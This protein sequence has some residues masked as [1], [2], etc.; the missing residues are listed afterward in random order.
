MNGP[1]PA[2]GTYNGADATAVNAAIP[3]HT[4]GQ[5]TGSTPSPILSVATGPLGLNDVAAN[6]FDLTTVAGLNAL[7]AALT[8]IA[9]YTTTSGPPLNRGTDSAPLINLV[10][11]NPVTIGPGTGAGVLIVTGAL[12]LN[13]NFNFNGLI[14]V[15]GVGS[16]T[17]SG[18]GGGII[19]G[20][21]LVA[22]TLTG[23]SGSPLLPGPPTFDNSGAGNSQINY[24]SCLLNNALSTSTYKVISYRELSY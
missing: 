12:T 21:I 15:V 23:T 13:G 4:A 8:E 22:N 14:L 9:D 10:T 5:Y 11:S 24:N 2:I 20:A 3:G 6:G 17:R 18:G 1:R 16:L 19:N 7:V